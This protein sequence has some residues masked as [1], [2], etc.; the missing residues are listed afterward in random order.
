[1]TWYCW[2]L[3]AI[4]TGASSNFNLKCTLLRFRVYMVKLCHVKML[5]LRCILSPQKKTEP[6]PEKNLTP[7]PPEKNR[8]P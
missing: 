8:S 1:M 3:I 4:G 5:I 7:P 6:P 2:A